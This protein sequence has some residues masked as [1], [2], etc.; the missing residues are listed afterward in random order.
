MTM[1]NIL[2]TMVFSTFLCATAMVSP[3]VAEFPVNTSGGAHETAKVALS[4]KSGFVVV[5]KDKTNKDIIAR[6]Y[7]RTGSAI[8]GE[9][10]VASSGDDEKDPR[11][12][13]AEDGGFVVAWHN[14]TVK[15]IF[16]QRYD[17]S[18]IPVGNLISVASS[19]TPNFGFETIFGSTQGSVS[20]KQI[21]T[22]VVLAEAGTVTSITAYIDGGDKNARY[23]IYRDNNGE[24]DVLLAETNKER[25]SP[26]WAWQTLDLPA[27]A[28][29]AG[30]Y[31]LAL[32]FKDNAQEY[33]Y[34]AVGGQ[35]R[36]IANDAERRGYKNPWG[37]S[38]S[39]ST[40]KVSIFAT[41]LSPT[42]DNAS[43]SLGMADDGSFVVAWEEKIA[44]DVF[45]Q[46]YDADGSPL[47][48]AIEVA[49]SADQETLP[50][51]AVAD[52]GSFI[53]AWQN[54]TAKDVYAQRYDAGGSALGGA[55]Q[56]ASSSDDEKTPQLG[57]AEDGRFVIAWHNNTAKDVFA[58]R[59]DAGGIALGS[60]I[61]V[62]FSSDDEKDASICVADD[63]SFVVAWMNN[64]TK[65]VYLQRY[66][67]DGSALGSSI[68]VTTSADQDKLPSVAVNPRGDFVVVWSNKIDARTENIFG[69]LYT[70]DGSP[71]SEWKLDWRVMTWVEIT[72]P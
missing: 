13:V 69:Q 17:A 57:V 62:T 19:A 54:K 8:S 27:T 70:S 24:P 52:D 59:Y 28:L 16:A 5:W 71:V 12:C 42:S 33:C 3:G 40:R 30:T 63:G 4:A 34:D 31:W 46:R 66:D 65:D 10:L 58:Q 67:V 9:I 61:Q 36:T 41:V 51:V 1:K 21:A 15:D 35:T 32:T 38:S 7:D 53:V 47:G 50:Y 49:A 11:V 29:T 43:P 25:M 68:Q 37:A 14:N 6:Q 60:A 18:G 22:Q 26:G 55:I 56:V 2:L 20:K 23:A 72:A 44:D 45:A 39:S 48:S 64:T